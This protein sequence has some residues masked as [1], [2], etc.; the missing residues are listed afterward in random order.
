MKPAKVVFINYELKRIFEELD[1]DD[2]IKKGLK[3][4]ISSLKDDAFT[5]RRVK[6]NLVPKEIT[7]KYQITN[8]WVYNLPSYW[9]M[10][11]TLSPDEELKIVAILLDWMNHKDYE[12]LFKF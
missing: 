11:Y 8:L 6:N 2:P 4:A 5:G 1:E 10:L 7:K 9:R 3:K 12:R